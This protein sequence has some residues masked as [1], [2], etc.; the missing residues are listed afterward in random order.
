LGTLVNE[1]IPG[2]FYRLQA[3]QLFTEERGARGAVLESIVECT[4]YWTPDGGRSRCLWKYRVV[5]MLS[6]DNTTVPHD[7]K[8]NPGHWGLERER[9]KELEELNDEEVLAWQL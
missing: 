4:G 3:Y 1:M 6:V 9:I 2:K 7:P 5:H 8:I